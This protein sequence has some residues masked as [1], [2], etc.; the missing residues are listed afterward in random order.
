MKKL[1][2][3]NQQNPFIGKTFQIGRYSVVVDDV[4]AEGG[5][6]VVFLVKLPNGSR[7]ALKRM[8]VNNDRD[9]AVCQ[10]EIKIMK[11][12]SGHK[13]TIRYIESSITVTSNRVYEVL[14]LMQYCR[15][16]VIQVMNEKIDSGFTE[17]EILKIFCDTCEAVSRLH[18]CQTPI[19]H[20]DLKVENILLGDGGNYVL[21]DFGSATGRVMDPSQQKVTAIEEEIQ[22][23]T[24]LSYRAPEMIDL[25]G[26]TP[27]T[28]KSD[29]WA[30]GCL[31]YKLCFFTLPFGES[32]LAIQSVNY[33]IPDLCRY[34]TALMSL[35]AYML[36]KDPQKRPD[37]FQV[38]YVAFHL[39]GKQNPVPNMNSS[40][41][42]DLRSLPTPLTESEAKQ[43]KSTAQK[44]QTI[45]T[46]E[47]TTVAPRQ[48]PRGQVAPVSASLGLPIQTS[49][50]PRRRPTASNP[51]TPVVDVGPQPAP[52]PQY[53]GQ[54]AVP[55]SPMFGPVVPQVSPMTSYPQTNM[56]TPSQSFYGHQQQFMPQQH[57][58]GMYQMYTNSMPQFPLQAPLTQSS[59]FNHALSD[60]GGSGERLVTSASSNEVKTAQ[61][62]SLDDDV[63]E[64]MSKSDPAFKTQSDTTF[65]RPFLPQNRTIAS[66][67]NSSCSLLLNPP[68]DSKV[69]RHRRNVS[70]TSFLTMGGKGS[71]FR[72]YHGNQLSATNETKS[73]S[74]TNTPI[75]SPPPLGSQKFTRPLS[76]DLVEWNPFGDDN[77]GT[78][79]DDMMFGEEFDK[80][81]RGSNTNKSREQSSSDSSDGESAH[82]V[83]HTDALLTDPAPAESRARDFLGT[84]QLLAALA[85]AKYSQLID[86]DETEEQDEGKTETGFYGNGLRDV[87]HLVHDDVQHVG[88]VGAAVNKLEPR[89]RKESSSSYAEEDHPSKRAQSNDFGYQE[90]DDE[91]GSRPVDPAV[92]VK[93]NNGDHS[94]AQYPPNSDRIVG[95]EY[96]VRPLLDDD[97]LQDAY[98]GQTQS[99]SHS[100]SG[101]STGHLFYANQHGMTNQGLTAF[102]DHPSVGRNCLGQSAVASEPAEANFDHAAMTSSSL[103]VSPELEAGL[104]VF[105][106]APFKPKTSKR[107]TPASV[108]ASGTSSVTGMSSDVFEGAPFKHKTSK[109]NNSSTVTSPGSCHSVTTSAGESY[110]SW[111]GEQQSDV[112]GSAPFNSSLTPSSTGPSSSTVS[113]SMEDIMY[114]KTPDEAQPGSLAI[115]GQALSPQQVPALV[116]QQGAAVA[117]RHSTGT[118]GTSYN[119]HF[120][121]EL[122]QENNVQARPA[123]EVAIPE[124]PF[125]AVPLN[126]AMKRSIKKVSTTNQLTNSSIPAAMFSPPNDRKH[127]STSLPS[128]GTQQASNQSLPTLQDSLPEPGHAPFFPAAGVPTRPALPVQ[129][130]LPFSQ[131]QNKQVLPSTQSPA[132][133]SPP[134]A[135]PRPYVAPHIPLQGIQEQQQPALYKPVSKQPV[136]QPLVRPSIQRPAD[137]PMVSNPSP[138]QPSTARDLGGQED[139][140]WD[141]VG[142]YDDESK[143]QRLKGRPGVNVRV[144]RDL[145]TSAFANM[146]FNDE[147]EFSSRESPLAQSSSHRGQPSPAGG[148]VGRAMVPATG[149]DTGTWPRKHKRHA[150]PFSVKK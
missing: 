101:D 120:K 135:K 65:K 112:F 57:Q 27:I 51:N 41:V 142:D 24:T 4:I 36:E 6:A 63:I 9:L 148:E 85:R 117:A 81:R 16:S 5:F 25:Y 29:I 13:N 2:G 12:L 134:P 145:S 126:K 74:A 75:N 26:G 62:I 45:V 128:V 125:G 86:S 67:P 61:L 58:M 110:S 59:S 116:V 7:L 80:I 123:V 133:F 42:P 97:E 87:K 71:A 46:V 139:V 122:T 43:I 64:D 118:S 8:Y 100:A 104:D 70:D 136:G 22:K 40:A 109:S 108:Q 119:I 150:E 3:S 146:S 124:D 78:E 17:K 103:V 114:I 89:A 132:L 138:P 79:N 106:A 121:T 90:L 94:S 143:Y 55:V 19:I 140:V 48:R 47:S 98:G 14:I 84:G 96:G 1:F 33:T 32:S 21:C 73:K 69:N 93:V 115:L 77:F 147:D 31:L 39:A 76:A 107:S 37:I 95:H 105:S 92:A 149:Y 113:P 44:N 111:K 102:S 137:L 60:R 10:K 83:A 99:W 127:G 54:M 144:S 131:Y 38:S 72:A 23:Y 34:S 49:I 15:G 53:P 20:R 141:T 130:T 66:E 82:K 56:I 11:D 88:L 28:T 30:L 50:A 129:V 35:I 52:S 68:A 91:F 18:H